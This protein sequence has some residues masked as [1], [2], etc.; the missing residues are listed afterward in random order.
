MIFF[1]VWK[2][3]IGTVVFI[4]RED[5]MG[6]KHLFF[7]YNANSINKNDKTKLNE[8]FKSDFH[9]TII[10]NDSTDIIGA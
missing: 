4:N 10:V 6:N 2:D 8:F 7:L 9:P 3:V 1:I 5:F